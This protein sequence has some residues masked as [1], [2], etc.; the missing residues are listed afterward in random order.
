[1]T[2]RTKLYI[3]VYTACAM[4]L[5]NV[6]S[7]PLHIPEAFQWVLIIGVFI[8]LGLIFYFIKIQKQEKLK[9]PVST[10][11]AARPVSDAQQGVKKRL[12]LTMVLGVFVGLC[13]PLWLPVTGTT[14]GTRGDFVCGIITAAVVCVI[15]GFRLR[16][17]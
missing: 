16:K 14:L 4:M 5:M 7:K 12:I 3:T 9:Q 1:M 13:A 8:P 10:E 17:L 15:V 2:T 6:F 11:T